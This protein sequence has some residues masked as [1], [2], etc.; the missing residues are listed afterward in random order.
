LAILRDCATNPAM[1]Y[2][3]N[4]SESIDKVFVEIQRSITGLRLAR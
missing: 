1:A 4:D 3:A 2:L